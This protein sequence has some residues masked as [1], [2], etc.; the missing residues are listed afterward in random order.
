MWWPKRVPGPGSQ[1]YMPN[2]MRIICLDLGNRRIMSLPQMLDTV[3]CWAE[4]LYFCD[5]TPAGHFCSFSEF[6]H[7]S[8]HHAYR[9]ANS[10]HN[11][12]RCHFDSFVSLCAT[13]QCSLCSSRTWAVSSQRR[14]SRSAPRSCVSTRPVQQVIVPALYGHFCRG[15][16][17][18]TRYSDQHRL[19]MY[20][21]TACNEHVPYALNF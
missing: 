8:H 20:A 5:H 17:I 2:L 1:Q 18:T 7:D 19:A 10:A 12:R 15:S 11:F 9:N 14:R 16:F 3:K 21:R 6:C 4:I 13:G